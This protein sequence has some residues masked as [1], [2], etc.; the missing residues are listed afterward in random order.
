MNRLTE[1]LLHPERLYTALDVASRPCPVPASPGVY[2]FY[3]NEAPPGMV[4][5]NMCDAGG[6]ISQQ[7]VTRSAA[8]SGRGLP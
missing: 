6:R 8:P 2:A 3:F 1:A 4:E 5:R 7:F